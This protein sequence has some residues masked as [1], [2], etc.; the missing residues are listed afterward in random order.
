MKA[1]LWLLLG[2]AFVSAVHAE[3]SAL[4]PGTLMTM[5]VDGELTLDT[6]GK[7]MSYDISTPLEPAVKQMV[8][9]AVSTWRFSP[10]TADGKPA[11][12]RTGMRITLAGRAVTKGYAISVDNVT[13]RNLPGVPD[14]QQASRVQRVN[15]RSVR[16]TPPKYPTA[17]M[18]AGIAGQVLL[19]IRTSLDGKPEE[20]IAYQS[21]LFNARGSDKAMKIARDKLEEE[22]LR[23]ARTWRFKVDSRIATADLK[24]SDLTVTVPVE[25]RPYG[26]PDSDE[27]GAWRIEVRGEPSVVPWLLTDKDVRYAGVSDVDGSDDLRPVST[28]FKFQEDPVGKAL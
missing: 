15:V 18:R 23:I 25:Y 3:R 20:V 10:V 13:F 24:P 21:T 4:D 17:V 19:Y 11:Q 7:V 22:A 14:R 27:A 12:A 26:Q 28:D 6:S 2:L 9:R 16:M 5:R 1:G 8:D